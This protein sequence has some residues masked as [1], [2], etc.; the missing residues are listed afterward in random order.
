VPLA[1][2]VSAHPAFTEADRGLLDPGVSVTRR[3]S[4]GGGAPDA[5]RPQLERFRR[6]LAADE[7]RT[8]G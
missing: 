1:D 6:Q 7:E 2:L 8:H 5:V 3:T 4:P